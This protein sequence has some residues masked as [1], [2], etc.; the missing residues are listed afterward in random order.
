MDYQESPG[1]Q[2]AIKLAVEIDKLC[3]QLPAGK[4]ALI[5]QLIGSAVDLAAGL[6]TDPAA[7]ASGQANLLKVAT[8]VELV[9]RIYPAIDTAVADAGLAQLTRGITSGEWG[10]P[11][12]EPAA[13]EPSAAADEAGETIAIKPV[14]EE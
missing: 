1:W 8:G 5:R 4:D 6:A 10:E 9:R 13:P 2:A 14:V 7:P 11:E 12:P 3:D